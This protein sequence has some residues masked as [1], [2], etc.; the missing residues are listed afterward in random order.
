MGRRARDL[1]ARDVVAEREDATC[2]GFFDR[3]PSGDR[4]VVVLAVSET[5]PRMVGVEEYVAPTAEELVR[6]AAVHDWAIGAVEDVE[7]KCRP[8]LRS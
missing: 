5:R 3:K 1:T 8:V 6:V 4:R 2:T 7:E